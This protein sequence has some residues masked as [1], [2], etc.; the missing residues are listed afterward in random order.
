M[1]NI[2]LIISFFITSCS[3]L[4]SQSTPAKWIQQAG[5]SGF[6]ADQPMVL[7]DG[8]D[9]VYLLG[10]FQHTFKLGGE[11]LE[12][13]GEE[14]IFASKLDTSGNLIWIKCYWYIDEGSADHLYYNNIR[15][16]QTDSQGNLYFAGSFANSL[17]T[18]D[19]AFPIIGNDHDIYLMK[20]NP[21]GNMDWFYQTAGGSVTYDPPKGL[22]VDQEDN[23]LFS[24]QSNDEY[25]LL[26][27]D[28]DGDTIWSKSYYVP[29]SHDFTSMTTDTS[30]NIYIC[31]RFDEFYILD[32]DTLVCF[33]GVGWNAF[34][35][36]FDPDGNLLWSRV[37]GSYCENGFSYPMLHT[38]YDNNILLYCRMP[39]CA[40][41]FEG[42]SVPKVDEDA[43]LLVKLNQEGNI[44]W[45]HQVFSSD[46]L[47]DRVIEIDADNNVYF[48]ISY[49]YNPYVGVEDTVLP[50][51]GRFLL[52]KISS[53]GEILW[54]KNPGGAI[55][56]NL[57]MPSMSIDNQDNLYVTGHFSGLALFGDTS[58][59]APPGYESI[60]LARIDENS[61]I[62]MPQSIAGIEEPVIYAGPNPV[63]DILRVFI[64]SSNICQY[65]IYDITGICV[66][67]GIFKSN[68]TCI[69]LTCLSPGLYFMEILGQGYKQV[70]KLVKK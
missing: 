25:S 41:Y 22:S 54:V 23:I 16:A 13:Q 24:Y 36:K 58:L 27:L 49:Y 17:I 9:H 40:I 68:N 14:N 44:I 32:S 30:N 35:A 61:W 53:E 47:Y 46:D 18:Y 11:V 10:H 31:G 69:N 29:Y 7:Y 3:L 55:T 64:N 28:P 34:Y 43:V 51:D 56:W 70:I 1:L 6:G 42:D 63:S 8:H 52:S 5:I 39:N 62:P 2:I 65:R 60:Y 38:D 37:I 26:K 59:F 20:L 12:P 67:D 15:Y 21:E 19:T 66:K 48:S 4:F 33:P 50:G 45:D 57:Q